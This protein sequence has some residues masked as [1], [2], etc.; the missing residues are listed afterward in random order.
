[1]RYK[2]QALPLKSGSDREESFLSST[3]FRDY[4]STCMNDEIKFN[5]LVFKALDHA[6]ASVSE[7]GHL[8]PFVMTESEIQR[9]AAAT[10]E[11]AKEEA[12]NNMKAQEN[13]SR[14]VM[15]YDGFLT[16]NG[17]KKD[18]VF[19]EGVDRMNKKQLVLAQRYVRASK[20][21]KFDIVGNPVLVEQ[22]A[23]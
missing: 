1:M 4:H 11:E 15:A 2:M 5:D 19:V 22:N 9:Y 20:D 12:E 14:I 10:L 18:A 3:L 17:D 8:V 6:I 23:L 7:G 13:E 16:V 21:N